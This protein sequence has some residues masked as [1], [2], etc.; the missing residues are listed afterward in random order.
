MGGTMRRTIHK[1]GALAVSRLTKPGL[2]SDGGGL[3]L[4]VSRD[5]VRSWI[6]RFKT[7]A[8]RERYF[9]LGP[10]HTVSL[11]QA[12]QRAVVCRQQ[13]LDGIDPIEHRKAAR[14][15]AAVAAAKS[16]TFRQC[17]EAYIA[18]HQ[19]DWSSAKHAKQ[20]TSTLET[21]AYPI[22]GDLSA[23]SIGLDL[24]IKVLEPIWQ[25]KAT[26]ASRLRGRIESV[27]DWA[28]VRGFRS[29]E[30]PARWKG[31]LETLF[32]KKSASRHFAA[33]PYPEI[34]PF[35]TELRAVAGV[36]ARALELAILTVKR[37]DE[38]IGARWS[39]IDLEGRLWVIPAERMKT[40]R[41]HRLPL[42]EPAVAIL[43][44]LWELRENDFVFPGIRPGQPI[45]DA[46]MRRILAQ[47]GRG[48]LTAHGF[49]STFTDWC[50]EQTNAATE[51]REVALAHA[52]SNK[53]EAAYRRGDL[54]EKR[55]QLAEAWARYCYSEKDANVV[56]LRG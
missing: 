18:A 13:R 1:L 22:I 21:Y 40:R 38:V 46:A 37:T 56:A 34:A 20:W 29:G 42:S 35:M 28:T 27:L 15:A 8:G 41:E 23:H 52:V 6:F 53:V 17:A 16:M 7:A 45:G 24:I 51:T 47:M 31:H 36:A 4:Q 33:L 54:F 43:A 26:T 25:A 5:G 32:S 44:Q 30:N 39:E 14:N 2:Y 12:R 49:R 3:Y 9:G 48:D 19:S 11:K 55:R 10:L 50:T